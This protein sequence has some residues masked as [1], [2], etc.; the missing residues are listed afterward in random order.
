MK[1]TREELSNFSKERL[2]EMICE[3]QEKQNVCVPYVVGVPYAHEPMCYEPGGFCTNPHHDCVNC[4]AT[5]SSGRW[6]TNATMGTF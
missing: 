4:P 2:I 5:S 6:S 1:L 3:L